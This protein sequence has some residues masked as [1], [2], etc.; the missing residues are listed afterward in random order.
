MLSDGEELDEP[1]HDLSDHLD[2][3][4]DD[5]PLRFRSMGEIVG[6]A[7]VPRLAARVLQ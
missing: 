6:Q 4:H 3:D 1:H 2:I 7:P 5:A